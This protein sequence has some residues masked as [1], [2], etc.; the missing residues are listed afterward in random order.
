MTFFRRNQHIED[1]NNDP[2]LDSSLIPTSLQQIEWRLEQVNMIQTALEEADIEWEQNPT[3][4][5]AE[6]VVRQLHKAGNPVLANQVRAALHYHKEPLHSA[7]GRE[8]QERSAKAAEHQKLKEERSTHVN[9]RGQRV[10]KKIPATMALGVGAIGVLVLGGLGYGLLTTYQDSQRK[11]AEHKAAQ[12]EIAL[13]EEK[14]PVQVEEAGPIVNPNPVPIT[15]ETKVPQGID[16]LLKS[17]PTPPLVPPPDISRAEKQ[18]YDQGVRDGKIQGFADG[19]RDGY[20]A[21][22]NEY[23]VKP[24]Y[25]VSKPTIPNTVPVYAAPVAPAKPVSSVPTHK[26]TFTKFEKD[27]EHQSKISLIGDDDVA[28]S[29]KKREPESQQPQSEVTSLKLVMIGDDGQ[30]TSQQK[31]GEPTQVIQSQSA[32][33][34]EQTADYGPYH[35]FQVLNAKLQTAVLIFDGHT[36]ALPPIA[37]SEDGRKWIGSGKIMGA[38]R[39]NLQFN[40]MVDLD[41]T[42]H[43]LSAAAYDANGLPGIQ[44]KGE[45]LAPDLIRNLLRSTASGVK[46]YAEAELKATK[47][48]VRPDGSVVV[49]KTKPSI[50]S[51]IGGKALS[52]FD[53]AENEKTFT[54]AV[55]LPAG[56]SI[57][58]IVGALG[59]EKNEEKKE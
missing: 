36:M 11:A 51:V 12:T 8:Q 13:A 1:E 14:T 31:E 57:K 48:Y 53:L 32:P 9:S 10:S 2:E 56:T 43:A 58:L 50:W 38:Q 54:R 40:Q 25:Q 35:P 20:E 59:K 39:V 19:Q 29:E 6:Q 46:D 5:W 16:P 4:E 27:T 3:R 22:K 49:E 23:A 45:D 41:Q 26:L 47:T 7:V 44:G 42:V 55:Y 52:V 33:M 15:T 28:S 18:G 24:R 34:M 37:M 17:E 21:A 30:K